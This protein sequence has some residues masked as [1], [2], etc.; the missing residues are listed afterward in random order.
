VAITGPPDPDTDWQKL[1]SEY[2]GL[3]QY[4]TMRPRPDA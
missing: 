2:P 4:Q 3:E 1:L